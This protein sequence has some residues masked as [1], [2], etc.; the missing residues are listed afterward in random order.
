MNLIA[1]LEAMLASGRD[2]A[3]LRLS[4]GNAY[5]KEEN[6]AR[7]IEHLG[8]AVELDRH[9]SAA[10]KSYARA[11][12][13]DQRKEEA[14]AAYRTGIEVA[15]ERGD[16]QAAREMKVFLKRLEKSGDGV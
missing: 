13:Q 8:R 11:L 5:L 4:L 1:N 15:E 2:D 16:L 6:L 12:Q 10:W 14:L 9:Y 7:A 3:L